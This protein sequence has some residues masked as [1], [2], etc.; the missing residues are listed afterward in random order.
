M[1]RTTRVVC[2][3]VVLVVVWL[4]RRSRHAA[5]LGA[6]AVAVLRRLWV[7]GPAQRG[8]L[9]R[10]GEAPRWVRV[11]SGQVVTGR[12]IGSGRHGHTGSLFGTTPARHTER[13][14]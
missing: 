5:L 6:G 7:T 9:G 10:T 3:I 8:A 13:W 1:G 14:W 4:C 11:A 2:T 12:T